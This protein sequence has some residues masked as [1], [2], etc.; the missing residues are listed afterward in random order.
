MLPNS[1]YDAVWMWMANNLCISLKSSIP[2][3]FALLRSPRWKNSDATTQIGFCHQVE[4]ILSD[5]IYWWLTSPFI[6]GLSI[7]HPFRRHA[8]FFLPALLWSAS[9]VVWDAGVFLCI[10]GS[11]L[12]SPKADFALGKIKFK[13]MTSQ[14]YIF[15]MGKSASKNVMLTAS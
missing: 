4:T 2:F 10:L 7:S 11:L 3:L 12:W 14:F 5:G 9:R 15:L 8:K 13:T 1:S 6:C